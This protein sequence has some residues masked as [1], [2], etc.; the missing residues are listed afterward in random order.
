[1]VVRYSFSEIPPAV[2]N[3]FDCP[4]NKLLDSFLGGFVVG[5]ALVACRMDGSS[6]SSNVPPLIFF[7]TSFLAGTV[8]GCC[9]FEVVI[10]MSFAGFNAPL[11]EAVTVVCCLGSSSFLVVPSGVD[12]DCLDPICLNFVGSSRETPSPTCGNSSGP[13]VAAGFDVAGFLVFPE[14]SRANSSRGAPVGISIEARFD[15]VEPNFFEE[16]FWLLSRLHGLLSARLAIV[17]RFRDV[18]RVRGD[19]SRAL[20]LATS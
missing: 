13:G 3:N 11:R 17:C 16:S 1:M 12:L 15:P 19:G 8:G 6:R 14:S 20:S 4:S 9:C 2:L 5:C 7:F 18:L 10:R